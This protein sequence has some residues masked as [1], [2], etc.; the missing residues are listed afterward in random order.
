MSGFAGIVRLQPTLQQAEADRSAIARMAQA[1][2]FRGPDAQQQCSRD[3]ASFAFSLLTTGPAPQAPA[4]PF[5]VDGET[6]LLGDVRLDR[7]RE[8]LESLN[9]QGERCTAEAADEEIVLRAWKLW[10]ESGEH[11]IFFDE[12]HGDYS[13]ALWEPARHELHCFRNV[14]GGRPLYYSA[15]AVAF[16]FS[17]TLQALHHAPAFSP[18]LDREYIGDF[19]LYSWCPRPENTVFSSIRRLPAG[20]WL[21]YSRNGLVVRRFQSLPI[22]APIHLKRDEEY[23]E[24]YRDLLAKSVADRLPRG[25]ACV[26][27]SGGMDSSTIAA[28]VCALRGKAGSVNALFAVTADMRPLFNDEE[29]QCAAKVAEHLGIGF[30]LSHHGDCVPFSRF[31]DPCSH[32][33]EPLA[34]PFRSIYLHMYRQCASRSRVVFLGYGG[35]EIL[36]GQTGSYLVYLAKR[37]QLVRAI[38]DFGGY[39]IRNGRLP[40]LRAG[41]RSWFRRRFGLADAEPKFPSWLAPSFEQELDLRKRWRDLWRKDRAIHPVHPLGYQGLAGTGW[42]NFLDA[43]DAAFTGL[44][45][46]VRTPLFDYRLLR[47]LLRLPPLPWCVNKEITRRAMRGRLPPAIL[48]RAKHPLA[49][50]PLLLH[51]KKGNWDIGHVGVPSPELHQFVRWPEFLNRVQVDDGLSFWT[52]MNPIALN[53]WLKAVEKAKGIQ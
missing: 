42:P 36:T 7:R 21:R 26:F 20:H 33:P 18:G 31:E 45:L 11:Q 4:Q 53:L 27:L 47:F 34:N 39:F 15:D 52:D 24:I 35:D 41:I 10:R 48:E 13:F 6:F 16:S 17:N 5:T 40:P 30:E 51:R 14:M 25:S 22:E 9:H 37:G 49:D 44:P 32:F 19:L 50:D 2:R 1:I 28:T 46:E 29:G 23:V 43:E 8:L 12:L 3:G 38:K